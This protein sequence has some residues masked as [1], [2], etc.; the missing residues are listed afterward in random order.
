[1]GKRP[2]GVTV[3]LT[4]HLLP[5]QHS[6]SWVTSISE[7]LFALKSRTNGHT[8]TQTGVGF[9]FM[10]FTDWGRKISLKHSHQISEN[11]LLSPKRGPG[12]GVHSG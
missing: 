7:C 10:E 12:L 3:L 8:W 4:G 9:L 5:L 2:L 11:K 1:M 6:R